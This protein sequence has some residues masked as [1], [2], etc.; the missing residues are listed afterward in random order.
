[1]KTTTI[2]SVL[3]ILIMATACQ[4]DN[5]NELSAADQKAFE[6]MEEALDKA[7]LYNDSLV[8]CNDAGTACSQ[9][10]I[11]YCDSMFHSY[12]NQWS[13]H[14]NNY[15]HDNDHDDHHH[16]GHGMHHHGN[17]NNHDDS[18]GHHEYHHN[19]MD[20]LMEDHEPYHP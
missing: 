15:S 13:S 16:D 9:Q 19:M 17:H 1:M 14:H 5:F 10:Y 4:K 11:E 20:N 2:Y 3:I 12:V 8:H 18:E 7:H 6:D